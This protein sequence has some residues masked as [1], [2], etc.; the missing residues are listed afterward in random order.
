MSSIDLPRYTLDRIIKAN[1]FNEY[2]IQLESDV[3]EGSGSELFSV[4]VIESTTDKKLNFVCKITT[5]DENRRKNFQSSINF[6]R[7]AVFY[8]KIVPAFLKFQQ[9]KNLPKTDR[10]LS[11]PKCY[12][13]LIDHNNE[14]YA[15]ILDD[16]RLHG[17]RM[18]NKFNPASIENMRLLMRE[19]GKFHGISLA[20]K[21]QRPAEFAEF[22]NLTDTFRT[23]TQAKFVHDRFNDSFDLAI[24]SLKK[25]EHKNIVRDV[26]ENFSKYLEYCVN[27]E[28][29]DRF[30]VLSHG[31]SF[32]YLL[33]MSY[34]SLNMNE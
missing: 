20:M 13:T 16:L 8:D 32:F 3:G 2:S 11:H 9:E 29:S 7:E 1:G 5:F 27:N 28:T 22:K 26:K 25:E 31:D 21:D 17:F 18:W 30:G 23:F 33:T 24:K 34:F 15:I 10:F 19:L 14:Q 4:N 6:A 12:E